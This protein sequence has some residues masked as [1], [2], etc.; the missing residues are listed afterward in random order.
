ML[1]RAKVADSVCNHQY[2]SPKLYFAFANALLSPE[3][4]SWAGNMLFKPQLSKYIAPIDTQSLDWEAT[5]FS[6]GGV[7]TMM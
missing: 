3:V 4:F 2:Q 5:S 1:K 6:I 7:P